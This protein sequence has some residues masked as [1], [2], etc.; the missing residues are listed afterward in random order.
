[1]TRDER[2]KESAKKWL[3]NK[4]KGSIVGATGYGKTRIAINLLTKIRNTYPTLSIL[5][6]VP[7]ET[8]KNQW[9]SQ[10]A[11]YDIV[12]NVQVEIINTI[13]K[14]TWN[15]DILVIDEIHHLGSTLFSTVFEKVKYKK[16]L[17][18]TATM[19]RL[20]GKE[21]FIKK[22][23]PVVDEVTI[24][25]C[26][27][28]GWIS[29]YTK[30]KVYIDVDLTE[31]DNYNKSYTEHFAYFN[32][33][34]DLAMKMIGPSGY[35]FRLA[36]RDFKYT[37]ND[38]TL[39]KEFLKEVTY[40]AMGFIDSI[41]KRKNFIYNHT[42]KIE[43]ANLILNNRKDNKIIT[44]SKAVKIAR[45]LEKTCGTVYAG[46]LT[47]KQENEI[48]NNFNSLKCGALH[49]SI[50]A[51]EGLDVKGLSVG[52]V[53]GLDSSHTKA[54]Q[55]LGRIIRAEEGK[56]A[57]MFVLILRNTV[58]EKWFEKCNPENDY[59]TIDV[60][61]LKLLLENKKYNEYKKAPKQMSFRF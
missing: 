42:S 10:L 43:I 19:E 50:K 6:I 31:Y 29:K 55:Q 47:K 49:T 60:N 7:T 1:M 8:L 45:V 51:N 25:E 39:K 32:Y 17:G 9:I 33:D 22:Y 18:L 12:F 46:K 13:V 40:H 52:I 54:L 24:T 61:N 11:L 28:H 36:F 48:I 23:C 30:Y 38:P 15:C 21:V 37:G 35:K 5:V 53:L 59:I 4:G 44:F 57:E 34:Y 27:I 16:I 14:H 20:D 56:H 41:Q 26:A 2:Q 58:E 3:D